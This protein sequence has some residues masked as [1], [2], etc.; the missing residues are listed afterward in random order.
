[1]I[2]PRTSEREELQSPKEDVSSS[3]VEMSALPTVTAVPFAI[4]ASASAVS[5]TEITVPSTMPSF[6]FV[7]SV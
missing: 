3:H 5:L 7:R 6:S 1:M 4:V 2:E